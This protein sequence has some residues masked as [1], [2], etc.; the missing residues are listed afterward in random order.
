MKRVIAILV[1]LLMLTA[2]VG[3]CKT[4]ETKKLP[5]LKL[6]YN[7]SSGHQ[8]V[9]ETVQNM[10]KEALGLEV[11]LENQ[12]W[13]VFQET[14]T[15]GDFQI[16]RHGWL[17][18]YNDP[19]TFLDMWISTSGQNDA[20]WK[21]TEF[22]TLIRTAK[23]SNDQAVR[24]KAMHDAEKL[25]MT[26]LAIIPVYYYTNVWLDNGLVKNF[27]HDNL[28]GHMMFTWATKEGDAPILYHLG[29]TPKS[30][31]PQLNNA[32][33]GATV[34][35]HTFVGLTAKNEKNEV[36]PAIAKDWSV[37]TDG[38]TWTFNL[39][40]DAVWTDGK[41]V[42]AEDFVYAWRRAVDPETESE[43]AYQAWYIKNGEKITSGEAAVDTLGV[44]AINSKTLE[45][46][47]E[48][49]SAY[50]TQLTAFPTLYPVREDI[51]KA[52]PEGWANDPATFVCNGPYK[53]TKFELKN[54]IVLE[55]NETFYDA[56][57][58]PGEK[59]VFK[60]T[61]DDAAA[62]SAFKTGELDICE[63]FPSEEI[64]AMKA[65]GKFNVEPIVGTYFFCVNVESK[66]GNPDILLDAKFRKAL[67]LAI[68]REYVIEVVQNNALPAYA[69][70]PAG[71]VDADGKDFRANGG[72]YFGN[73]DYAK[74]VEEAQKLI[75]ELG[76]DVPSK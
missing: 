22:D 1:V 41:P 46:V 49:P 35:Q 25:L 65:E 47:L 3:G 54:E 14:R 67:A 17:G 15:Q 57:K 58:L 40:D 74:D 29:A 64:E 73:G 44:K 2:I 13:A 37:S 72:N 56:A 52:N 21:N 63:S 50:F 38:L 27:V 20:N 16:A 70:V 30:L 28:L 53:L 26:D 7:T 19:M 11:T 66:D 10:W 36:V 68:D 42:T 59:L 62:L 39:R 51:V 45:V 23:E 31:D 60:L 8:L 5:T 75:K 6:I 9:A 32:T 55:K 33:D 24:M 43:Y 69:F 61:D 76:Y 4:T 48:A 18:D 34:I 12:E 71:M